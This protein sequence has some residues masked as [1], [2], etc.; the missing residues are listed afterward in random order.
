M[1]EAE[2]LACADPVPMLDF[3]RG[4]ASERKVRLFAVGCCRRIWHVLTNEDSRKAV[5]VAEKYA[6]TNFRPYSAEHMRCRE[7]VRSAW[8]AAGANWLL[9][10]GDPMR[11]A[12]QYSEWARTRQAG[13]QRGQAALLRCLFGNPFR[14]ASVDQT[15]LAWNGETI[16]RLAEGIYQERAF[17]G[18]PILADALEEASCTNAEILGHLREPGPHVRGCWVVDLL[19]GRA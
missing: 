7:E 1:T 18:L 5:A 4:R 8:D 13:E 6:D 10:V 19:T 16:P 15:W 2:W 9:V 3:L 14:P 12:F 17:D 11:W